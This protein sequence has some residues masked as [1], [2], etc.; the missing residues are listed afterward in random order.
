M[1]AR[2][3]QIVLMAAGAGGLL[4]LLAKPIRRLMRGAE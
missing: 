1:P 4:L 2:F 3:L